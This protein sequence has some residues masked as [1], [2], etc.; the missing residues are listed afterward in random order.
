MGFQGA[1]KLAPLTEE[2]YRT[3]G[4]S[5]IGRKCKTAGNSYRGKSLAAKGEP[6]F[7]KVHVC[8]LQHSPWTLCCV[9][10]RRLYSFVS[11]GQ[12]NDFRRHALTA[13]AVGSES[14]LMGIRNGGTI[15]TV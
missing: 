12:I 7:L 14:W 15:Q 11:A 8:S 3:K 1:W 5:G 9:S 4:E 10:S 6:G 13:S 2:I